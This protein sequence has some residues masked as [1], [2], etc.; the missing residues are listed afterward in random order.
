[1]SAILL[2]GTTI[3]CAFMFL[4]MRGVMLDTLTSP[5]RKAQFRKDERFYWVIL[6]LAL[7]V[8]WIAFSAQMVTTPLTQWGADVSISAIILM[9]TWVRFSDVYR[10]MKNQQA[11]TIVA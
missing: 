9:L 6:F 7:V 1:M 2:F 11:E 10:A 5:F 8:H 3:I 4:A